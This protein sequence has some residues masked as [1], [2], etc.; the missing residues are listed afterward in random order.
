[1]NAEVKTKRCLYCNTEIE[2]QG[3]CSREHKALY[4]IKEDRIL[5]KFAPVVKSR[6]MSENELKLQNE[7]L[8]TVK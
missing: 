5:N 3:F 6:G 1:M 8:E 7:Y 4:R 2:R